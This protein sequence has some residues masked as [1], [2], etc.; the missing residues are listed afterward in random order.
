MKVYIDTYG[1][2][3]NKADAQIMGGVLK[4]NHIDL[5]DSPELAD[6]IIV[7]T[8]YV[9]LPTENKVVYKFSS[10]RK[11]FQIKKLS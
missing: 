1:C 10:C 6:V 2:T 5:V 4:E 9:K 11:N 7:N 8:C 3:F